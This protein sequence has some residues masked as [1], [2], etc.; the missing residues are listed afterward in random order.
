V[1]VRP[2]DARTQRLTEMQPETPHLGIHA[3]PRAKTEARG[4]ALSAGNPH[5]RGNT[6]ET[7]L[8]VPQLQKELQMKLSFP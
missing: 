7:D 8:T 1:R 6:M 4:H 5:A 2:W 3:L